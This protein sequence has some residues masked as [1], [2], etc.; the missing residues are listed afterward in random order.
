MYLSKDITWPEAEHIPHERFHWLSLFLPR[1]LHYKTDCGSHVFCIS[2]KRLTES[3]FIRSYLIVIYVLYVN[4][5]SLPSIS[6]TLAST[7]STLPAT[8]Q[9]THFRYIPGKSTILQFIRGLVIYHVYK[10]TIR[11]TRPTK[12][13]KET[14]S[15]L[16]ISTWNAHLMAAPLVTLMKGDCYS[17]FWEALTFKVF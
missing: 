8:S 17:G 15:M 11:F 7:L 13:Y 2:V 1:I 9:N 12:L 6:V 10:D 3:Q 5:C 4:K 14:L 16:T